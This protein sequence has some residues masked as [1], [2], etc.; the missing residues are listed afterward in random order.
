[1]AAVPRLVR[2]PPANFLDV[3]T[4][5][6]EPASKRGRRAQREGPG[7]S[8][9]LVVGSSLWAFAPPAI[10][11]EG[12]PTAA[13]AV[14]CP[15]GLVVWILEPPNICTRAKSPGRLLGHAAA[16]GY[17]DRRVIEVSGDPDS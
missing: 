10:S 2:L 13:Y 12:W 6:N 7:D 3:L 15:S 4:M 11:A 9:G 8:L 5:S 14:S 1:V 16:T 17:D